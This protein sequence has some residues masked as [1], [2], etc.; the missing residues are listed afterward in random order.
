MRVDLLRNDIARRQGGNSRASG[1]QFY[2]ALFSFFLI[3]CLISLHLTS[4]HL[5]SPHLPPQPKRLAVL[6]A[7]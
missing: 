4:P 3:S 2:S 1:G 7:A 5:T 6:V